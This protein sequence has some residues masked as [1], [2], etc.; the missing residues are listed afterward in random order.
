M[1][2][3]A[4]FVGLA[5][6]IGL[7]VAPGGVVA[8]E[9][10]QIGGVLSMTGLYGGAG[11][12]RLVCPWTRVGDVIWWPIYNELVQISWD[13]EKYVPMIAKSWDISD[14]L[15]TW[16]FHLRKNVK[17]HDE[18][19]LTA[20][21]VVYSYNMAANPK[22]PA[23]HMIG[24]EDVVGYKAY[25]EGKAPSLIGVK[26]LDTYTVQFKLSEPNSAF[27]GTIT[28]LQIVPKHLLKDLGPSEFLSASFW[29]KPVGTGPFEF[30]KRVPDQ[31]IEFAR[32]DDY[33][34]GRPYLDKIILVATE[35]GS[36][37]VAA[38]LNGEIMA[39]DHHWTL[40][41]EQRDIIA[42]DKN[43]EVLQ[44]PG[45][46]VRGLQWNLCT[47]NPPNARVRTAL[48][49]AID[50]KA[51]VTN[52]VGEGAIPSESVFAQSLFQAKDIDEWGYNPEKA[53]QILK[54]EGW[55][56]NRTVRLVTYYKG[57]LYRNVLA[58][59]Q[60]YWNN[61]GVKC[62]IRQFE[63]SATYVDQW[64]KHNAGD[65]LLNGLSNTPGIPSSNQVVLDSRFN[66]PEGAVRCYNNPQIDQLFDEMS[67]TADLNKKAEIARRLDKVAH[68]YAVY[69][70]MWI[71]AETRVINKKLH[72]FHVSMGTYAFYYASEKWWI[73][74]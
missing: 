59:I 2:K 72:G 65:V 32:F 39:A 48:M 24:L 37:K 25:N 46:T 45:T 36:A 57:D 12:Q 26:A 5:F 55:D 54:E 4:L 47:P 13:G 20:D 70:R 21:D 74:H 3:I 34:L 49:M 23:I 68:K 51:I 61:I 7:L 17:F 11:R 71:A 43:L 14:D 67:R 50:T 28:S 19:P 40:S 1:K 41:P 22:I 62:T 10:P 53:R 30:V 69:T 6:L 44:A 8:Q 73:E 52:I 63:S 56:F 60:S 18:V 27:W 29:G 31:Y 15:K 58:A 35:E 16:T 66:Y 64:Y 38:L 42:K 33:F 9:K